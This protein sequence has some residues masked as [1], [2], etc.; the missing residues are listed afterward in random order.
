MTPY[1]RRISLK[2]AKT[3]L[4]M[5]FSIVFPFLAKIEFN[6]RKQKSLITKFHTKTNSQKEKLTEKLSIGSFSI[7][8]NSL[9]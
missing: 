5:I 9:V 6:I 2:N 1:K 7:K 8:S 4:K 3:A